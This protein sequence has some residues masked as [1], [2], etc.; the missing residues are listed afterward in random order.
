[1]CEFRDPEPEPWGTLTNDT[2]APVNQWALKQLNAEGA[3]NELGGKNMVAR[4]R[5]T[6]AV[7]DTGVYDHKDLGGQISPTFRKNALPNA[8]P[9][10]VSDH[11][12]H[13]TKMTGV[14]A[15]IG[16]NGIG[17]DGLMWGT[18]IA[19]CKIADTPPAHSD[20][21]IECLDWISETLISEKKIPVT[22][23]NY[24]YASECCSD[25][26]GKRIRG[27]RDLGVLFVAA[28]GN[29]SGS[30]DHLKQGDCPLFPASQ[31]ISNIISVAAVTE[32]GKMDSRGGPRSVHVGAPGGG[33]G[34][35][36]LG[37]NNQIS[38]AEG[39]SAAT[40][41]VSGLIALLKAQGR[42]RPWQALRNLVLA[43]GSHL[44]PGQMMDGGT[45]TQRRILAWE[46]E[47]QATTT[48]RRGS[49]SCR[50]QRVRRRLWPTADVTVH[51]PVELRAL[52]IKCAD[53]ERPAPVQ[54]RQVNEEDGS[55]TPIDPPQFN[56]DGVAPDDFRNDGEWAA[57][58]S[59]PNRGTYEILFWQ[60]DSDK[61]GDDVLRIK[62]E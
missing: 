62:V 35:T 56:D 12:G 29:G 51:G 13:G 59:P 27:L 46:A 17:I 38:Y 55:T 49:M 54:V 16:G 20:S 10:D 21:V 40:A 31:G 26:V 11:H 19:P 39:S 7:V 34:V 47:P 18:T 60:V 5:M 50:D 3:W 28:A 4:H 43:G 53:S 45:I 33:R 58:F 57:T 42:H 9:T 25:Q 8:T 30:N 2:A 24:S 1:V 23:I 32:Q 44:D 14:I 15:A 48:P 41:H 61:L 36:S 6:I 37:V 22:A 52:S